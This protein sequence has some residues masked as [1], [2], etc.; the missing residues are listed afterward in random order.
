LWDVSKVDI[1]A[2]PQSDDQIA[3]LFSQGRNLG[4]TYAESR[5]LGKLFAALEVTDIDDIS[6]ALALVRPGG[7]ALP[8]KLDG[9]SNTQT[10]KSQST[11]A[12]SRASQA[13]K[14]LAYDDESIRYISRLLKITES[15][16]EVFRKA[17]SKGKWGDI[18]KF[19]ALLKTQ[20]PEWDDA[21]REE[22]VDQLQNLRQYSFCKSHALSYAKLVWALAYQKVHNPIQFWLATLN[23]CN[24]SYRK[25]V[26]HREAKSVGINLRIGM[27]PW[28]LNTRNCLVG[29][30][31][32]GKM[33]YNDKSD[34]FKHGY[35][36]GEDFLPGM[37]LQL[38][39]KEKVCRGEKV[40]IQEASFR[41][42]IACHR[43]YRTK[44][45]GSNRLMTFATIGYGD[46]KYVDL[47]IWGS[48]KL[49]RVHCL[50]GKGIFHPEK[51]GNW[52]EVKQVKVSSI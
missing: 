32:I 30:N 22:L 20:R 6:L 26:H 50:E 15:E 41:G 3:N 28:R 44:K 49:G 1:D 33:V 38:T 46:T 23:H 10:D 13:D 14:F 18:Q 52:I 7:H 42:L 27:P 16:A 21:T 34:Y 12:I 19:K 47:I 24:S 31:V 37:F 36:I 25:W 9:T 5:A 11:S 48:Y 4:I 43:H 39:E 8:P 35:W 45:P 51:G 40:K 2:Y 29:P 17:F